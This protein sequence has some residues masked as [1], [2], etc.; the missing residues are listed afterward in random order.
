[1]T[2]GD[3]TDSFLAV[4]GRPTLWKP[5]RESQVRVDESAAFEEAARRVVPEDEPIDD[6]VV[7]VWKI[8]GDPGFSLPAQ[9]SRAIRGQGRS[10]GAGWMGREK[11]GQARPT[12]FVSI[13]RVEPAQER[14]DSGGV[15]ARASGHDLSASI[16]IPFLVPSVGGDRGRAA[17]ADRKRIDAT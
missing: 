9:S 14:C 8:V 2:L 13:R 12:D 10:L 6:A 3:G 17:Q 4:E 7:G 16:G 15:V 1:M 11:M 5:D